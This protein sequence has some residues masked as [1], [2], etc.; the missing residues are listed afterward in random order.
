VWKFHAG[1]VLGGFCPEGPLHDLC[2]S[3]FN[4]EEGKMKTN[5]KNAMLIGFVLM[6]CALFASTVMAKNEYG[7]IDPPE[8][9]MEVES[10]VPGEVCFSWTAVENAIKYSVAIEV[11]A[12]LGN[13][14][15][16][17][18]FDFSS[19]DYGPGQDEDTMTMCIPL[20]EIA[21]DTNDDGELDLR[22]S[23]PATVKVK[24]LYP[25][26]GKGRQNNEFSY[27]EEEFILPQ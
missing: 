22:L 25:G 4:H 5:L 27:L 3:R 7:L 24:G 8:N 17:Y 16:V 10:P 2:I 13:G 21:V 11:E 9:F 18:D 14:P 20:D 6:I 23:G 19:N 15:Q 26:K 12:D 1:D